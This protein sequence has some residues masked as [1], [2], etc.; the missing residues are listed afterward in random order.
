L[1]FKIW[2]SARGALLLSLSYRSSRRSALSLS[3]VTL[4]GSCSLLLLI[5]LSSRPAQDGL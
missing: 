2:P 3:A 4:L 5:L 1:R